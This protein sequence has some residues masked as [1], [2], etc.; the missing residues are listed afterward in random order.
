MSSNQWTSMDPKNKPRYNLKKYEAKWLEVDVACG[1]CEKTIKNM[2][3][4]QPLKD[5][6]QHFSNKC[7]FCGNSLSVSDF[8]LEINNKWNIVKWNDDVIRLWVKK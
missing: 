3:R 1:N 4:L 7:P 8:T 6:M 5:I 2:I